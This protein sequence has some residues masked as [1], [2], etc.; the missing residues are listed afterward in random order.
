GVGGPARGAAGAVWRRPGGGGA[1]AAGAADACEDPRPLPPDDPYGPRGDL[2]GEQPPSRALLDVLPALLHGA[3]L[4]AARLTLASLDPDPD[5]LV[6]VAA[7][8]V[9]RG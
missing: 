7:G 2:T 6:P 8:E 9:T 3:E 4:A 1:A 5:E